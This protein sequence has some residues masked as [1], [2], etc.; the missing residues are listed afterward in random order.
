[1]KRNIFIFGSIAGLI[2]GLFI[3]VS[4]LLTGKSGDFPG[5]ALAGYASMV[6]AFSFIYVGI[7]NFREKYNQGVISYGKALR[8]GL[9]IA[10]IGS[11]FY[12]AVWLI[13]YYVFIPDFMEKYSAHMIA[14]ARSSGLSPAALD[15]KINEI[16]RLNAMYKNPFFVILMT[17]LEV[18]PVGVVIALITALILR[19]RKPRG[20]AIPVAG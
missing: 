1:M 4:T 12:V 3:F 16:N 9:G 10:L 2:L 19:R 18:L 17:Y 11:T 8:V 20:A 14:E 7:R 6:I 13:D 5:G 15:Q